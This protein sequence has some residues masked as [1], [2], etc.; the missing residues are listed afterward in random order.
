MKSFVCNALAIVITVTTHAQNTESINFQNNLTW[1]QV[2]D[3]AKNENKIVFVDLYTDW[4]APCK[5]ME[6]EIFTLKRVADTFNKKFVNYRINAEKG[7]GIDVAKRYGVGGYPYF[8]FVD[9]NGALYYSVLG[10]R[11]ERQLLEDA[12]I[13]FQEMNDPKPFGIWREEYDANR[14]DTAWM[15]TYIQ[16]RN[17][18]RMDNAQLIDDFY[19]LLKPAD[20]VK[21]GNLQVLTRSSGIRLNGTAFRIVAKHFASIPAKEDSLHRLQQNLLD[22]FETSFNKVWVKALN[23]KNEA[24]FLKEVLP[25]YAFFP[26]KVRFIPWYNKQDENRWKFIF[27]RHTNDAA[28]LRKFMPV[29]VAYLNK[30]YK[31]KTVSAIQR[32]DSLLYKA[33]LDDNKSKGLDSQQMAIVMPMLDRYYKTFSTNDHLEKLS[34]AA[35]FVYNSSPSPAQLAVALEWSKRALAI[36]EN[37]ETLELTARLLYRLN[38]K[39]EAADF[40]QS[41]VDSADN[42]SDRNRLTLLLKNIKENKRI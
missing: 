15:R 8:I 14:Y 12:A 1:Q 5:R 17:K 36:R 34:A 37:S 6:S 32:E 10:Y 22:V 29:A 21:T 39:Q 23:E 7:E 40:M 42:P 19:G 31:S 25:A 30:Y 13:A 27:Y 18:L 33:A 24:A 20:Y 38:R 16:K 28:T 41:A 9:G 26:Q 3:K 11:E 35:N 2:L 4:C